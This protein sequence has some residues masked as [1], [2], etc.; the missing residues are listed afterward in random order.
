MQTCRQRSLVS[1]DQCSSP[2][3]EATSQGTGRLHS[4]AW[5]EFGS[6]AEPQHHLLQHLITLRQV[7][8]S[9]C[10]S[11]QV[12]LTLAA[13]CREPAIEDTRISACS[14]SAFTCSTMSIQLLRTVQSSIDQRGVP[15]FSSASRLAASA[16]SVTDVQKS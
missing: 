4:R 16:K 8:R 6:R 1:T 5:P 13:D 12:F 11:V 14:S 15:A 9:T 10:S 7:Q 3:V 2:Y